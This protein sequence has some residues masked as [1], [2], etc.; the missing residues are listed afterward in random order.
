MTDD[1]VTILQLS[2][3]T[4]IVDGTT[5]AASRLPVACPMCRAADE[6]IEL[7]GELAVRDALAIVK[8]EAS[9]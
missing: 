8:G 6:I 3:I 9:S 1:I 7:R 2:C 4:L 5:C